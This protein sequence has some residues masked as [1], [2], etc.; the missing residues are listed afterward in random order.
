MIAGQSVCASVDEH[1]GS[2][3]C[4]GDNCFL[5]SFDRAVAFC[6]CRL[7]SELR[8]AC[9]HGALVQRLPR[10]T[11]E[12]VGKRLSEL[13]DSILPEVRSVERRLYDILGQ[14]KG[15]FFEM[16]LPTV[17]GGSSCV[18]LVMPPTKKN[19]QSRE[20]LC[21]LFD[22][23][24]CDSVHAVREEVGSELAFL[25]HELRNPLAT[26]SSGLKILEM[27]T[28]PEEAAKARQMMARQ[29]R[30]AGSIIQNVFDLAHLRTGRLPLDLKKTGMGE[31]VELALETSGESIKRGG[32][33]LKVDLDDGLPTMYADKNR[34][35]QA[36]SNLLDNASK[37]T[38]YGGRISLE[39][40]VECDHVVLR[41]SDSGLGISADKMQ[42]IFGLFS[43]VRHHEA[44]SRGGLGIGLFLVKA[45][46]QG[47]GGSILVQSDGEGKGSCFTLRLP[48]K[49]ANI[50]TLGAPLTMGPN[51]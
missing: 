45:I 29:V 40:V 6:A 32:H 39:V 34:L 1:G 16:T 22:I 2:A 41:V 38:P 50:A 44:F 15:V 3:M 27:G 31:I 42:R 20:L 5:A 28:S 14:Q 8:I 35:A 30:H 13:D 4:R 9:A 21:V 25:A 46:A 24:D 10:P 23:S 49:P 12:Y 37:Y 51:S 43:Q 33:T 48:L 19:S 18:G 47:H 17:L 11:I 7:D 26:I 36:L